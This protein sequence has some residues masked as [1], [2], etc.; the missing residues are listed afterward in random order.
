MFMKTAAEIWK[1]VKDTYFEVGNDAQLYEL[2]KLVQEVK[3]RNKSVAYYYSELWGFS[4]K[5]MF[6]M[7]TSQI[8]MLLLPP[9]FKSE[10]ISFECINF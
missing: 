4:R 9:T 7:I 8:W 5:L 3:Q 1:A 6:M 2:K 10:K